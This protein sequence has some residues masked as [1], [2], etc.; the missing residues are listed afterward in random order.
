MGYL[1]DFVYALLWGGFE[2]DFGGGGSG[3]SLAP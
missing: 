3:S 1:E 2:L